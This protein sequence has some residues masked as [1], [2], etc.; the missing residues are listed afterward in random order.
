MPRYARLAA[1][2]LAVQTV[3]TN[4]G[5]AT[6]VRVGPYP[7]EEAAQAAAAQVRSSGL[8]QNATVAAQPL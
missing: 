6:R 7:T 5:K 3:E 1:L 2:P 4:R 8:A